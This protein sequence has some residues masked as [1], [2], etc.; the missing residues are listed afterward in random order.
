[1]FN[2]WHWDRDEFRN[3]LGSLD[4]F[5]GVYVVVLSWYDRFVWR[6]RCNTLSDTG[7]E[8]GK[9]TVQNNGCSV[10]S[11]SIQSCIKICDDLRLCDHMRLEYHLIKL[12]LLVDEFFLV[13]W[14]V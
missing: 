7:I 14:K 11:I 2:Q 10:R 3:I 9:L 5:R 4:S 13:L 1:M 6:A 8:L 12:S